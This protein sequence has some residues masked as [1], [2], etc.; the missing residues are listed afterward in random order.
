VATLPKKE[1]TLRGTDDVRVVEAYSEMEREELAGSPR[2]ALLSTF[3]E[4]LAALPPDA[5]A[6]VEGRWQSVREALEALQ[7]PKP[8]TMQD[9]LIRH[10][11]KGGVLC[12][13]TVAELKA[14][15]PIGLMTQISET[16]AELTILGS[17]RAERAFRER[18]G[19]DA[20]AQASSN[21]EGVRVPAE[22]TAG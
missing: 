10:V 18:A 5:K 14:D 4:M 7:D 8:V 15:L 1:I 16:M 19:A 12:Y 2:S 13:K 6:G 17:E 20:G 11:Y 3:D 21:G 9:I 22:P